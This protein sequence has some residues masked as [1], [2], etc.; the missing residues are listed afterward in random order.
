MAD[1]SWDGSFDIYI[2]P[3]RIKQPFTETNLLFINNGD[4]TFTEKAHE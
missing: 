4:L 3:K 1:I 2:L